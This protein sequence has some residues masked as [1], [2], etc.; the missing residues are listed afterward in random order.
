MTAKPIA[1]SFVRDIPE[2]KIPE[3]VL[4]F[5]LQDRTTGR[6]LLWATDDYAARGPGFGANDEMHLRQIADAGNPVIRPRVDKNA[7]EQ[8]QRAVRRAEIFTPSWICNKQNNLVDAAWFGWKKP[9]SSPFNAEKGTSWKT[10]SHPV[11]FPKGRTW[12]EYVKAPR[13]EVSCGEAPYLASRYDAVD[14]AMLPVEDRIGLLDRKLRI[15]TENAGKN[16]PQDWFHYAKRAVQSC[17]GFDWQGDNVLLARENVLM[18]V[19]ETWN[20]VFFGEESSAFE[21]FESG[22]P[23]LPGL[24]DLLK[25]AEIVAWNVWQMDGTKFVVPM[26]CKP[27]KKVETLLDGTEAV[28]E[29]DCRGCRLKDASAH[30]GTYSTIMDWRTGNPMR[31]VDLTT[32]GMHHA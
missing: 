16:D 24:D 11:R 7:A 3:A 15:V 6:N 5:L 19:V 31:F 10:T 17:Y 27:E 26:S 28:T 29:S 20:R 25:L 13:L 30:T 1:P 8:R 21:H 12:Q 18:T 14:G 2:W 9:A 32:K 4:A 22:N 23:A